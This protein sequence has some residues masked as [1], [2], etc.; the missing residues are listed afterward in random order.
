MGAPI[1]QIPL[2]WLGVVSG[3]GADRGRTF[4][5]RPETVVGRITGDI[6]LSGDNTVS[7]Q[8]LKVRLEQKEGG[9]EDEQVFVLYDLA[10]ANGTFVGTRQNYREESSRTYR[11]ELHSGDYI[12]VGETTLV[13][14][15]A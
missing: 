4:V 5:L 13:F 6:L 7:A 1:P 9:A 3:P 2:A 10:S 15:Q 8:H 11:R 14:L 12:L